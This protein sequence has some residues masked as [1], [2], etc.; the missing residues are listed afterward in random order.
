[1]GFELLMFLM[2]VQADSR[3]ET[4]QSL[5]PLSVCDVIAN[6]PTKLNGKVIKVRGLLGG[7]DEGTWLMEECNTHLVTKGL[8]WENDLSVYVDAS[9]ESIA[10]SWERM[11]AE[12]R[13]LRADTTRDKVWVTIVGRLETRASMEDEVAQTAHGLVK[14]GFGHMSGSPAEINV[15]SVQDI[16]VE[17]RP[18]RG[19]SR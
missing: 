7:T 16:T 15:L 10:R 1:M 13:R 12:L 3:H 19:P 9:D 17:R 18:S 4:P 6:D 11:G 2:A 14:V 8:T 5:A